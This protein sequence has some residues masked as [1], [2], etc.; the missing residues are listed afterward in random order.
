MKFLI[1]ESTPKFV[2]RISYWTNIYQ[3]EILLTTCGVDPPAIKNFIKIHFIYL[4]MK[5]SDGQTD[6]VFRLCFNFMYLVQRT[7]ND[8]TYFNW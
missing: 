5:H 8:E 2:K 3:N 1:G 4:G 6:T 7:P